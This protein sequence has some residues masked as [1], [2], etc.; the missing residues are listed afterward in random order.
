MS[1]TRIEALKKT[2]EAYNRAYYLDDA[3]L[4][5]DYDYDQSMQE[6]IALETEHPEWVTPDSP[7]QRV[8]GSPSEGFEKVVYSRP[9]LSLSNA[10]DA[11]DLRD[12]DRRV[13]QTCPEANYVV[14]YKFDGLTVVLNYENGLFIQ[15]ATRG[16]GEVGEN[17]TTNLK[18][19]RT[20]PLRLP[21][22]I[23]LE[24]RGEVFMGK[25]DFEKLNQRRQLEEESPFANPRNAA[26]GSLRQL[27]PRLTASR[28]LDIFVFNLES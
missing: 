6:L 24:V 9:K 15:G 10:F 8:G 5:S 22:S 18:T 26:A 11:G 17:V 23:T 16:D 20:I 13:R 2:I 28:P 3:P 19:I 4:V 27:D 21:E 1:N 14:E 25:A 7:T 12:F